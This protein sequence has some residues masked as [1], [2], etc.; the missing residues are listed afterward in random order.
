LENRPDFRLIPVLED[1]LFT[2]NCAISARGDVRILPFF[3]LEEG[4]MDGFFIA[5]FTRC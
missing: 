1:E 3:Q 4:G 5:R 2:L